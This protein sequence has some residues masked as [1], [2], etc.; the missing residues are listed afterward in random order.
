MTDKEIRPVV[1]FPPD[2]ILE[3]AHVSA[4][5]GVSEEVVG[6][7]DLPCFYAG[8]KP[9]FVWRQVLDCLEQ[10]AKGNAA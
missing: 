7:M 5:L 8:K 9:R 3:P 10:R 4:A 1:T 6:K 2:A